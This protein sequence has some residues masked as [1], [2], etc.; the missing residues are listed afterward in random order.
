MKNKTIL[1]KNCINDKFVK[2]DFDGF[3]YLG[4]WSKPTGA[5]F[6]CIEPWNGVAD[7]VDHDKNIENKKG[8]ILLEKDGVFESSFSIEV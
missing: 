6:L 3:D 1:Y 8:I 5:S 4:L 7:F 2:V